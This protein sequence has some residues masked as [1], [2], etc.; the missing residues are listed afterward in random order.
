M[1]YKS[2]I[3]LECKVMLVIHGPSSSEE[4]IGSHACNSWFS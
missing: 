2:D 3:N 4:L 1:Y